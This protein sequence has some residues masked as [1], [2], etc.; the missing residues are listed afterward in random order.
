M[1]RRNGQVV[2]TP[3]SQMLF[4]N[5][6]Y[7]PSH[8]L[9][10][11]LWLIAVAAGFLSLLPGLSGVRVVVGLS[12]SVFIVVLIRTLSRKEPYA[13]DLPDMDFLLTPRLGFGT[14]TAVMVTGIGV[15]CVIGLAVGLAASMI[16]VSALIGAAITVSWRTQLTTRVVILGVLA[17]LIAGG[18]IVFLGNGDLSWAIFNLVTIPPLFTGG[19]LL[20]SRTSLAHI[21]L[22]QGEYWLG[23]QG[24]LWACVLALPASL[25]NLL[26]NM[27]ARD[28]WLEHWWQPLFAIVPGIAEETWA[29]LFLTTACYALLRPATNPRPRRA[30]FVAILIGTLVWGFAHTGI[31]PIGL[32]VGS[33]LYGIPTALLFIK[34]DFEH[35]V[36]Y[37]FMIDF[38]RYVAALFQA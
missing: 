19:A 6:K 30:V 1:N 27:Q 8:V 38:V 26:G 32:V 16:S 36:G 13:A 18:G 10:S 20:L 29:R 33:L 37:H 11:L 3:V 12:G 24:F 2:P 21:R 4:R 25:L 35:A 22:L 15:L 28:T 9:L 5:I 14:A 34:Y 17:G 31:N 7:T 23:L